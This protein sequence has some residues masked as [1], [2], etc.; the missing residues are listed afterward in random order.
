MR[1]VFLPFICLAVL[2]SGCAASRSNS[3]RSPETST[4]APPA[5]DRLPEFGE[6]V[7]V[8][9]LPEVISKVEPTYPDDARQAGVEGMVMVQA[10]VGKDGFVKDA[11]A[12]Q[13]IPMLD[14]AAV[15]AVRQWVFKP[16]RSKGQPVAVWVA[17]PV[18]FNLH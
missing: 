11:R 8:E 5:E 17:V 3:L 10:L 1:A 18:R 14:E 16:A 15:D 2:A 7:Y 9:E 13:S 6:Y 12:I 4:P